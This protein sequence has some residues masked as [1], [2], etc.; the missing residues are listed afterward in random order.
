ME[1]REKGSLLSE[2]IYLQ[3]NLEV[4]FHTMHPNTESQ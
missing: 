3:L 4:L 2:P 1:R